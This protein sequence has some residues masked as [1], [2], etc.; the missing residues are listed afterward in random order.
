MQVKI[1]FDT[2][3]DAAAAGAAAGSAAEIAA[4]VLSLLQLL[5]KLSSNQEEKR[6]YVQ[7]QPQQQF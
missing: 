4:A 7:L 1:F 6:R 3:A 2:D 5:W